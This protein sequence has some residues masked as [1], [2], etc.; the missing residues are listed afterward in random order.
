MRRNAASVAIGAVLLL[1]GVGD[2][3]AQTFTG[4]LRG[5]VKD[6]NGV[7]PGATVSLINEETNVARDTTTNEKGGLRAALFLGTSN[8]LQRQLH[9]RKMPP[10]HP[11]K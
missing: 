2:A 11:K 6:A 7:L 8:R 1:A 9:S 4:S 3:G 5:E 10:I